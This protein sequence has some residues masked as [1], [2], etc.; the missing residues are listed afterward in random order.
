MD[1]S[2]LGKSIRCANSALL[3]MIQVDPPELIEF[4]KVRYS[5]G[6][7]P[8]YGLIGRKVKVFYTRV[9]H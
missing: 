8:V 6:L 3:T 2:R 9:S 1:F 5:K 7:M 4:I